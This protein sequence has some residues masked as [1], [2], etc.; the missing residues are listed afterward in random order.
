M[1]LHLNMGWDFIPCKLVGYL[2]YFWVLVSFFWL[3]VMCFDIFWTFSSGVVIKNE[4]RRFWYYS[5]YAWGSA[6]ALT[7]MLLIIE[8]TNLLPEHLRPNIGINRCFINSN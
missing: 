2:F 4:R 3:N 8:K 1:I 6:V 7:C 5:L